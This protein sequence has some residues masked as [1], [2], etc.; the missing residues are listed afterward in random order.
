MSKKSD[1]EKFQK[2]VNSCNSLEQLPVVYGYG[3]VLYT[4]YGENPFIE[5]ISLF[6]WEYS[7]L[8]LSKIENVMQKRK[9]KLIHQ[10]KVIDM[11]F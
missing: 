1:F 2:V 4:K 6:A 10:A 5:L 3:R 7:D 9:E 11:Q 8:F